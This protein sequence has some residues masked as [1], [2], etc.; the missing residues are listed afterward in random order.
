MEEEKGTPISVDYII[1][2]ESQTSSEPLITEPP[3]TI[4]L[5]TLI[6]NEAKL[7]GTG[8]PQLYGEGKPR[9][10]ITRASIINE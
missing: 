5:T 8:V 3:G 2:T 4:G 10:V 1:G 7:H 6:E 9:R